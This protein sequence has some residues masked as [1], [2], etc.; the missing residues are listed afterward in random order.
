LKATSFP[1]GLIGFGYRTHYQR[2]QIIEATQG[3]HH[4]DDGNS[5]ATVLARVMQSQLRYDEL[6]ACSEYFKPTNY[7]VRK[8]TASALFG[9]SART[10]DSGHGGHG[11]FEREHFVLQPHVFTY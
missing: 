3:Q 2:L 7:F 9:D 1:K 10:T 6:F 8:R 4:L 5:E 11:I